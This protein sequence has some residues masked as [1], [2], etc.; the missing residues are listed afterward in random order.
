MWLEDSLHPYSTSLR[1]PGGPRYMQQ[2]LF[3]SDHHLGSDLP[4]SLLPFP[5]FLAPSPYSLMEVSSNKI[6]LSLI[7]SWHLLLEGL[8]LTKSFSFVYQQPI[9]L[10]HLVKSSI[11]LLPLALAPFCSSSCYLFEVIDVY[12]FKLLN[13]G[14]VFGT[15]IDN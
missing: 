14:L 13:L 3:S 7:P 15:A 8:G 4:L 2:T 6:L 11:Q 9:C 1:L 5:A 12:C 10:F